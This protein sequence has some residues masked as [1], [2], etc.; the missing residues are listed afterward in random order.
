MAAMNAHLRGDTGWMESR[1]SWFLRIVG[2]LEPGVA[3]ETLALPEPV[4]QAAE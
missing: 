1:R 3:P 2:R 4:R